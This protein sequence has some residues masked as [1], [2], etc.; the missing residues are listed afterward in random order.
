MRHEPPT[1]IMLSYRLILW[2]LI[3]FPHSIYAH[4]HTHTPTW[5]HT[6]GCRMA[7]YKLDVLHFY[8]YR[9]PAVFYTCTH[10]WDEDECESMN[11]YWCRS[12]SQLCHG[13][14]FL[15]SPLD[16]D[17]Y[18]RSHHLIL[19]GLTTSLVTQDLQYDPEWVRWE[20]KKAPLPLFWFVVSK[21]VLT[22]EALVIS[23]NVGDT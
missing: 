2:G 8:P 23:L 22:F 19:T 16:R 21:A 9:L 6:Y 17:S 7:V 10:V 5:T 13:N 18:S 14:V 1:I 3:F 12:W 4:L 15:S 20:R 11:W